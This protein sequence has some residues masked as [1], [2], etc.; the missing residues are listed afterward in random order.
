MGNE[1]SSNPSDLEN[2]RKYSGFS[3]KQVELIKFLSFRFLFY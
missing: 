1:I 3:P 2:M